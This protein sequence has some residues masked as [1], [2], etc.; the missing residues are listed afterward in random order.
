MNCNSAIAMDALLLTLT[1]GI[2]EV[3]APYAP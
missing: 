2:I 3:K 1:V